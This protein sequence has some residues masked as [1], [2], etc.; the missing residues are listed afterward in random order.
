MK[1]PKV[2]ARQHNTATANQRFGIRLTMASEG[3]PA[4]APA[5][6]KGEPV[7]MFQMSNPVS[8]GSS[9]GST[10]NLAVLFGF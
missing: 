10:S 9:G 2:L 6:A 5:P 8:K 7:P 3:A 1:V 4:P